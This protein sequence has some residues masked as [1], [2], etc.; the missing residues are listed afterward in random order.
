MIDSPRLIIIIF[1][2][3]TIKTKGKTIMIFLIIPVCV[4]LNDLKSNS[5]QQNKD[6]IV[7]KNI[8]SQVLLILLGSLFILSVFFYKYYNTPY[9]VLPHIDYI[10]YSKLS[11]FIWNT[12]IENFN[13]DYI[14]TKTAG[15]A[16]YHYFE[17]WL[18]AILAKI[19]NQAELTQLI[20]G[21]YPLGIVLV[22]MGI[23]VIASRILNPKFIINL[24]LLLLL[25]LP[26]IVKVCL[27][28]CL[29]SVLVP[30]FLEC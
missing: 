10:Q 27:V 2:V 21:T 18:N 19:F 7:K 28:T 16:P 9:Y 4:L 23:L 29:L 8:F 5:I 20:F 25:F 13:I 15:V 22:Y 12:T 17:I 30:L 3:A 6:L 14:N 11:A 24:S 26:F 1:L